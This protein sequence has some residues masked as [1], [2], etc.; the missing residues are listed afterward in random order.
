MRVFGTA[1]AFLI[2]ALSFSFSPAAGAAMNPSAA[3][4]YRAGEYEAAI[5]KGEAVGDAEN[6]AIAAQAAVVVAT[7]KGGP[8]LECAKRAQALAKKAIAADPARER[9]YVALVAAIG[10]ESRIIGSFPSSNAH[11]PDEARQAIDKALM[12]APDDPW[13]LAAM[14]GWHIEIVR[15]AGRLFAGLIYGARLD[16]GV[17]YFKRAV[18][19]GPDDP[20]VAVNYA[21]ELSTVAFN[22]RKSEIKEALAIAIKSMPHDAYEA[23]M[24]G[25]AVKLDELLEKDAR[26][27]YTQLAS[28]YLGFP[29]GSAF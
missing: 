5:E 8:C 24:R 29:S 19:K 18:E 16:N 26:R 17:Q 25:R 14:G 6:L 4:L 15:M 1:L 9:N 22:S 27:E 20:V 28:S 7:L 12:L 13:A 23:A 2:A 21:L 11:L 10:F 3:E